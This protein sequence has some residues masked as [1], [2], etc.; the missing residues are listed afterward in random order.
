MSEPVSNVTILA[1]YRAKKNVGGRP[2]IFGKAMSAA[3]RQARC[4]AG[5]KQRRKLDHIRRNM[6]RYG[7]DPVA[8][9]PEFSIDAAARFVD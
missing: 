2:P 8:D 7:G 6:D 1:D 5:K 4:R 3:E 9:M